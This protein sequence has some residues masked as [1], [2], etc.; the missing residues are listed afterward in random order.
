MLQTVPQLLGFTLILVIVAVGVHF[1]VNK[2]LTKTKK[3]MQNDVAVGVYATV[4]VVYA[5]VIGLLVIIGQ[6]RRDA[7]SSSMVHEAAILDDM[8]HA[9]GAFGQDAF[10]RIHHAVISYTETVINVEWELLVDDLNE[11]VSNEPY[12]KLWKD[13]LTIT[14]T[15]E[16]QS[17]V[18]AGMVKELQQLSEARYARINAASDHLTPFLWIVLLSG[19]MV[20]VAFPWMFAV[21]NTTIHLV[22]TAVMTATTSL[23]LLLVLA[24]DNPMSGVVA[25]D[26]QPY[27]A[28]LRDIRNDKW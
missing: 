28:L 21:S 5:V 20:L 17:V 7:A 18:Y 2:R 14:P 25:L 13:V 12:E 4:S 11:N 24:Y 23:V 27:E 1:F 3:V 15:N 10:V 16:H 9:S 26:R 22:M 6:E 8:T 19:A